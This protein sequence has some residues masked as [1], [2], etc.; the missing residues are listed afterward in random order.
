MLG[1]LVTKRQET[2][3]DT[4]ELFCPGK[5]RRYSSS[6]QKLIRCLGSST[7]VA[8]LSGGASPWYTMM[9]L[10][11]RAIVLYKPDVKGLKGIA[12]WVTSP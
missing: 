11:P 5:L 8:E 2:A 1:E 12:R 9:T 7:T 3:I 6:V 4:T 10:T